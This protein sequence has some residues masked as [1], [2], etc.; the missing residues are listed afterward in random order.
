VKAVERDRYEISAIQ[1][2]SDFHVTT[3]AR[4]IWFP[5]QREARRSYKTSGKCNIDKL[6]GAIEPAK[7]DWR[8]LLLSAK[9][10]NSIID[11]KLW[12][13]KEFGIN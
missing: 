13:K 8:V 12:S 7:Q 6:Y 1:T 3:A 5:L 2:V 4:K 11:H 9:F 10:A